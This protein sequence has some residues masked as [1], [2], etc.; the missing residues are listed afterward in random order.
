MRPGG[1]S[2]PWVGVSHPDRR[3]GAAR[4]RGESRWWPNRPP[5]AV[6]DGVEQ[7]ARKPLRGT[8]YRPVR[9][10]GV[11]AGDGRR[12]AARARGV[13]AGVQTGH[14]VRPDGVA[15]RWKDLP[16]GGHRRRLSS[17]RAS[18]CVARYLDPCQ[19]GGRL[20]DDDR[21]GAAQAR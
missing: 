15:R 7:P 5:D 17:G 19:E 9:E 3:R 11:S 18:R 12:G 6:R 1:E 13:A 14:Q 8:I 21:H 10:V 2:R 20:A 4:A 16:P